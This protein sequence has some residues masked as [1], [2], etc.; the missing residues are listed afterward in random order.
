VWRNRPTMA[1]V[2]SLLRFLDYTQWHVLRS[3]GLPCTSDRPL[4]ATTHNTYKRQTSMASARFEPAIP[5]SKR[6]QGYA[7][8]I[9]VSVLYLRTY[10][11]KLPDCL[12]R[13]CGVTFIIGC[14][15]GFV[16]EVPR[17]LRR[18][19]DPKFSVWFPTLH[20]VIPT[21]ESDII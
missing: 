11:L 3:M 14:A 1:R 18:I 8:G 6:P 16:T 21:Y 15:E 5:A 2:A 20:A 13:G 12:F 9:G 10:I 19:T 4:P 7:T 17:D